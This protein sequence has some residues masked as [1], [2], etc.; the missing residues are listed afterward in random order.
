MPTCYCDR[1]IAN[2]ESSETTNGEST[3]TGGAHYDTNG[4]DILVY[5]VSFR[6][7]GAAVYLEI[8]YDQFVII[9]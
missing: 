8:A 9:R 5:A 4:E 3:H 1:P 6:P 2:E 7:T